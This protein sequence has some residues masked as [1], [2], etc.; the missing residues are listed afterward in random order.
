[1]SGYSGNLAAFQTPPRPDGHRGVERVSIAGGLANQLMLHPST[2]PFDRLWRRTPSPGMTSGALSPEKPFWCELGAYKVPDNMMLLIF[3]TR[4]DVYRPSGV[5]VGD[6]FPVISR[7]L[8]NVLG[9]TLTVDAR[10]QGNI[11]FQLQP[12]PVVMSSQQAYP[13]GTGFNQ[14]VQTV[15]GTVQQPSQFINSTQLALAQAGAFAGAAGSGLATQPQCPDRYGARDL[16]FTLY[17][18]SGQTVQSRCVVW[19]PLPIPIAFIEY[20]CSGLLIPQ[21][22]AKQMLEAVKYPQDNP[23]QIR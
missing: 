21:N 2:I 23:E 1:M 10:V 14:A 9:F 5:A 16:P 3:D 13:G 12:A 15:Y 19:Q 4:P 18:E 8:S 22:I 17:A 6:A 11:E 7:S 20:R